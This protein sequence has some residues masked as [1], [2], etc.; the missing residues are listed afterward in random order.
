MEKEKM[1]E[2]LEKILKK[3]YDI[4]DAKMPKDTSFFKTDGWFRDHSWTLKQQEEFTDWL[5]DYLKKDKKAAR[6]LLGI[7]MSSAGLRRWCTWFT[8]NYGWTTNIGKEDEQKS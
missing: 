4:V 8:F 2:A 6:E 1:P 3:M 5:Y 7:P